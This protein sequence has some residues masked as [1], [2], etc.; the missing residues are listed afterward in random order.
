[1]VGCAFAEKQSVVVNREL[2]L[3]RMLFAFVVHMVHT[4]GL[5]PEDTYSYPFT[6]GYLAVEFFFLLSGFFAVQSVQKSTIVSRAEIMRIVWNKYRR[7]MCYVIPSTLIHYILI[8]LLEKPSPWVFV[9]SLVY[10]VFEMALLPMSGVYVTFLNLPLWYLSALFISLPFFMLLVQEWGESF[11]YIVAPSA[12]LVLYGYLCM[13]TGHIDIWAE[14]YGLISISL[15]RA[16]AGLCLGGC[17]YVLALRLKAVSFT[18]VGS[19]ALACIQFMCFGI[20]FFYMYTHRYSKLDFL[21]IAIIAMGCIIVFSQK[22]SVNSVLNLPWFNQLADYSLALYVSHWS[23]RTYIPI[24]MPNATY[25]QMLFPYIICSLAYAALILW[26]AKRA[27]GAAVWGK[28][29]NLFV[30]E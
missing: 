30:R 11:L 27:Q 29:R 12:S 21:V 15:L 19:R 16:F 9:R 7:I 22:S 13:R 17:C 20:A 14:Q 10:S 28:W 26:V 23:I 6:E 8:N 24:L 3:L 5:S 25:W 4:S 1:M 2:N 18:I